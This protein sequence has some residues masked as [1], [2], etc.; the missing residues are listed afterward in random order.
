MSEDEER[1][2]NNIKPLLG[3]RNLDMVDWVESCTP[4]MQEQIGKIAANIVKKAIDK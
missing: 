1:E 2:F 4:E 3:Y